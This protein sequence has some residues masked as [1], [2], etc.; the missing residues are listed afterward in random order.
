MLRKVIA[1][2]QE[3]SKLWKQMHDNA[4][5]EQKLINK[6]LSV[7]YRL[8]VRQLELAKWHN[9]TWHNF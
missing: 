6:N 7:E 1:M 9:I 8:L 5:N 4:G 2:Q 3:N